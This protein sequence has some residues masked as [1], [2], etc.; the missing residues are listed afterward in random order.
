MVLK[1]CRKV[2]LE[3]QKVC[4]YSLWPAPNLTPDIGTSPDG[5]PWGGRAVGQMTVKLRATLEPLTGWHP[6]PINP[7]PAL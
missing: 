5:L 6:A 1:I 3:L 2:S 7:S 4:A